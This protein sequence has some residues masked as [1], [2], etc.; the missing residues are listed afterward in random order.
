VQAFTR[1]ARYWDLVANSGRFARALVLL[2]EETGPESETELQPV[3][4]P[5]SAT[6][7][8]SAF[9]AF[10]AFADWLWAR[11]QATSTLTPELL[12]DALFDYLTTERALPAEEVRTALLVDYV[13]SGARSNPKALQGLLP[14]RE[15]LRVSTGQATPSALH[16][17]QDRHQR[18]PTP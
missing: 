14:R 18:Q 6:S 8:W 1:L 9:A 15:S 17:R 4:N 2:L 10:H 5:A 3:H 16:Q 7:A 11:T 13:A 12:L